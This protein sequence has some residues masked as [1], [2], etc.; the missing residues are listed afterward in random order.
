MDRKFRILFV[1]EP[2]VSG[3]L[4]F[5]VD[6]ANQLINEHEIYIAYGIRPQ[7]PKDF[8]TYFDK[9]IKLIR[10]KNFTRSIKPIKDIRSYFE[11]KAIARQVD[12]DIVHLHSSKAGVIGRW[13]FDGY[14]RP[15]FY[16]PHGYSFLMSDYGLIKRSVFR[17]IEWV[18]ALG[19]CTT[20]SCSIGEHNETTSITKRAICIENGINLSKIDKHTANHQK[21]DH[22]FT[23]FTIGR[24]CNQ[25]N[26]TMFNR[27]AKSMPM[28]KFLWI[29]DGELRYLLNSE[30]IEVT[31]WLNKKDLI[32]RVLDSDVFILPSLWEGL[33]ISLLEAMYLQKPCIVSDVIGNHD[34][35]T[36]E[37][38]GYICDSVESF[39]DAITL[40]NEKN[41]NS[42]IEKA[43]QDILKLYNSK[44]MVEKYNQVYKKAIYQN[45]NKYQ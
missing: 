10:V 37:I 21:I 12:P 29:G 1:V 6:L 11:I 5:I 14:K 41:N 17:L 4:T 34:V 39:V 31:G 36:D 20:I 18:S 3:I 22:P 30:N 38:N 28:M 23:V 24:I 33:P 35:I 15:L 16:T 2:L 43:Y 27:I 44:V 40:C 32:L 42:I 7:T 8:E 25:K 45:E 13:A 26:P 19:G 9:R